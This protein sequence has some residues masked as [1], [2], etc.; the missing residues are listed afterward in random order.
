MLTGQVTYDAQGNDSLP[1]LSPDALLARGSQ[2]VPYLLEDLL[3]AASIGVLGGP[4]KVGKSWLALSLA[5]AVASG[6]SCLGFRA[7]RQER[8]LYLA[9]EDRDVPLAERLGALTAGMEF[10]APQNLRFAL[11][12]EIGF[13]LLTST[14]MLRHTVEAFDPAL[15]IVDTLRSASVSLDEEDSRDVK[16]LM[17]RLR[18]LSGHPCTVLLV[19]HTAKGNETQSRRAP[20]ERL[21]GSGAIGTAVDFAL[22]LERTSGK[23]SPAPA[24]LQVVTRFGSPPDPVPVRLIDCADPNAAPRTYT[25]ED[26]VVLVGADRRQESPQ[27]SRGRYNDQELAAKLLAAIAHLD[28]GVGPSAC[29]PSSALPEE[30]KALIGSDARRRR[31]Y[32][33]ARV[34]SVNQSGLWHLRA[35]RSELPIVAS[36][37]P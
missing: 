6:T 23:E 12:F 26:K 20:I 19:H 11:D 16:A 25:R 9:L 1:L 18:Q 30:L 28:D 15:V 10:D 29:V 5:L 13:D 14:G 24:R 34:E 8:V 3:P 27:R 33:A 36:K 4:A 37:G 35:P 2:R 31:V 22:L 21:S 32:A 17:H 7:P